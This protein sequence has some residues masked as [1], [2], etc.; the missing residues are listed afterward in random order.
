MIRLSAAALAA[1]SAAVAV[2]AA[3]A[4]V[5]YVLQD[6]AVHTLHAARL[7]RDYEIDVALPPSYASSP[8]RHYPVV[9]VTDAP[10]AFPLT[11]AIAARVG[12][13]SKALPEFILVGL[14]YARGDTPEYSRR[15][16]YTPSANGDPDARSDM[17][18]RTPAFGGAEAYRRFVADEVF[19]FIAARYRADMA[20]R[21]FAGHS[22]GSLW[23]AHV[24]ATAPDMFDAYVLGS[25]SLWFDH[26]LMF[27][28]EKAYAASHPGPRAAVWLGAGALEVPAPR[29]G[30]DDMV[31][32]VRAYARA[33][34]SHGWPG[35][36]L[37]TEIVPG[38]N[39]LT[40][41]PALITHGLEWALAPR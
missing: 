28:C 20:H 35:L 16:D 11:R 25:P 27:A 24:L 40:V 17:P 10:Y 2:R 5:P 13:H 41:A 15:R 36:A 18:G 39:H 38:E 32:D 1:L 34:A 26:R 3:E 29:G 9:F 31:G 19:P 23:G 6:T 12:G 21:V 4:P 33:L 22:Y 8:Q 14:G 7:D 30:A 37:H